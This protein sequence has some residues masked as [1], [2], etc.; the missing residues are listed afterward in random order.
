MKI[1]VPTLG[2]SLDS[3]VS[4][5]FGRSYF[6]MIVDPG[7]MEY[8]VIENSAVNSQGGAGIRAA[9][10]VADSGAEALVTEQCGQNAAN[11]LKAAG[12]KLLKAVPGTVRQVIGLFREGKLEELKEIHPGYHN[13]GR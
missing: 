12:I 3:P 10:L 7:T 11:V 1:A 8:K 4:Q 2:N 6:F 13:H 5:A 9:Q